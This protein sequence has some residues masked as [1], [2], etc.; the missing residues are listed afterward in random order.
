MDHLQNQ[1][2]FASLT[3]DERQLNARVRL[4]KEDRYKK[5]FLLSNKRV[6]LP[7]T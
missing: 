7:S 4:I 2:A 1:G 6:K 3:T 5:T